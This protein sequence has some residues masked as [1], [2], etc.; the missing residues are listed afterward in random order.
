MD[1]YV[2]AIMD[3]LKNFEV[4]HINEKISNLKFHI[5]ILVAALAFLICTS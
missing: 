2:Y 1:R 5:R 4:F 3:T